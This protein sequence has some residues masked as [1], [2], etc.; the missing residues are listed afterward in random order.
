MDAAWATFDGFEGWVLPSQKAGEGEGGLGLVTCWRSIGSSVSG[1]AGRSLAR[2]LS[3][4]LSLSLCVYIYKD[5]ILCICK[6][7]NHV[8][9]YM[10]VHTQYAYVYVFVYMYKAAQVSTRRGGGTDKH[11]A[12]SRILLRIVPVILLISHTYGAPKRPS[13][14]DRA[15]PD[16]ETKGVGSTPSAAAAGSSGDSALP[17]LGLCPIPVSMR[18]R[19][20]MHTPVHCALNTY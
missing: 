6:I 17:K 1:F 16:K 20:N 5:M 7:H 14:T 9:I 19:P 3:L 15:Q 11:P 12:M 13:T 2:S 18:S 8:Y 4:S 10:C